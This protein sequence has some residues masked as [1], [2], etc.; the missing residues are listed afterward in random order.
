MVNKSLVGNVSM[1]GFT[2]S[3]LVVCSLFSSTVRITGF[4]FVKRHRNRMQLIV[5]VVDMVLAQGC[6]S[7]T[8]Y[9]GRVVRNI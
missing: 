9:S 8:V 1:Y 2:T 3:K 5:P 6:V 7:L 4:S